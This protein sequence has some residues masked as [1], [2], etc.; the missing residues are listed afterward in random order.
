LGI[1]KD[2]FKP[3]SGDDKEVCKQLA[4]ANAAAL[5]Q[6][7]KD[8]QSGQVLL[9]FDNSAALQALRAIEEHSADTPADVAAKA[10]AWHQFCEQRQRT[11]RLG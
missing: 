7:A 4:K 6:I 8:L 9:G 10:Q 5:K 2:A 11:P 1:A 3:L